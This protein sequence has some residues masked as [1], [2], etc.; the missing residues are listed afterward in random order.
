MCCG[1]DLGWG[2]LS[3]H[4]SGC[5][6][7]Q[8]SLPAQGSTPWTHGAELNHRGRSAQPP[9]ALEPLACGSNQH[10]SITNKP[11]GGRGKERIPRGICKALEELKITTTN[12]SI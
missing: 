3:I 8:C 5:R 10:S 7:E 4:T 11:V 2:L 12:K 9:L 1:S 6:G